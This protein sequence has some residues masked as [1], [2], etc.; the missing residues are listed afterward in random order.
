MFFLLWRGFRHA[1]VAKHYRFAQ[2][3][4]SMKFVPRSSLVYLAALLAC[5]AGCANNSASANRGANPQIPVPTST[6]QLRTG[7]SL[8]IALQGVPDPST[9]SV[10]IDEQGLISLP[11]I[12]IL[13]AAG[14]G[15]ADLSQ[16]IRETYVTKKIYTVV[17]V[18]VS[19]TERFIYVG[20]EVQRP[21]RITWTTDL[22]VAKA[23]QAAGG[24]TLYAKETAVRLSRD[25]NS[26]TIDVKLAQ[27][28]PTQDPRLMPG[29]SLQVSRSPF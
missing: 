3:A 4:R 24:F 28:N 29:D 20:G 8:T 1:T 19:V 22:S 12:G 10:Q 17:D 26:Y 21:G 6:A 7:D 11:Y 2:L 16:R 5:A 18:S 27:K 13:A 15:T 23:I 14:L 25:N 9:N